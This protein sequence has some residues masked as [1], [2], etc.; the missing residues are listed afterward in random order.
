V[1]ITGP[2][3]A[4]KTTILKLIYSE[5]QPTEGVIHIAGKDVSRISDKSIPYLR[6]NVGVVYQDFK[7]I[8]DLTVFQNL[9]YALEIFYMPQKEINIYVE[10]MLKKLELYTKRNML[11]KYLS[12]GEKQRVAIARALIHNPE[13]IFA[14]EPTGS[15]DSETADEILSLLKSIHQKLNTTILLVTHDNL[16][17]KWANYT[18][19][20][21]MGCSRNVHI[22]KAIINIIFQTLKE[23]KPLQFFQLLEFLWV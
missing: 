23:K 3:G 15:L 17:A 10:S 1:Y 2:S 20:I 12:G 14:D 7:L 19:H 9:A 8:Y 16:V 22:F 13:I 5:I 11:V 21:M 18:I 4:G 6:R